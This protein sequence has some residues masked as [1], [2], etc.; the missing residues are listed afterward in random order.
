FS[1]IYTSGASESLAETIADWDNSR[2]RS[3]GLRVTIQILSAERAGDSAIFCVRLTQYYTQS[4][5]KIV[6]AQNE[7][8][9][10]VLREGAWL[11]VSAHTESEITYNDGVES[12]VVIA[13]KAISES[14]RQA[15]VT[16]LRSRAW[17]VRSATPEGTLTDLR[18]LAKAV[19]GSSVV[20]MG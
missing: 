20:G 5:H 10:W 4:S 8:D 3:P 13:P 1:L 2:Q 9:H 6:D 12:S 17:Q 18:P 14:E 11:M 19:D 16:D 15:I 7:T